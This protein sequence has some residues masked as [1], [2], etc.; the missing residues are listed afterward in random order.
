MKPFAI[1]LDDR[2]VSFARDGKVL[3]SAP[4][5]VWDGST[6]EP[7]GANAWGALRRHPTAASTRHLGSLLSQ[8]VASD[9]AIALVAAELVRRLA[10]QAPAADERVWIAAPARATADGLGAMLAIARHLSLPVD[11]F[12]DSTV[13]TAAALGLERSAIVLELGLYH[14]AATSIHR[15]A[16]QVRRGRTVLTQR[17]GLMAFYQAWLEL[18]STT[19]VKRTRFDPLHDAVTEQQLF[20][21]LPAWARDVAVDGSTSAALTKGE[22]RFEVALTR[23]QFVQVG[24][25]IHREIMRLVHELRP[26]GAAVT[27][28]V[29]G[30]IA[31]LPGLREELEQLVDCELVS[32][33]EGFAAAATSLL[34]LPERATDGPVRLLRRLPLKEQGP[35]AEGLSREL[36]GSR[37]SHVSPPS[38]LLLNGQVYSLG[39]D[40]L[41][42]GRSPVGGARAITLSDGLAGVSRRH[43]TFT[44]DG[45]ELVLLDHSTFGTFVNGE[46]VAERVRVRAGDRVRLGDPGVELALIAVDEVPAGAG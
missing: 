3:S 37:R 11:G 41:V 18:V 32:L 13:A 38:H 40:A 12:V 19:M 21:S 24:E 23:D 36:L 22:G 25:P 2:V 4:S 8:P 39:G 26:A 6:G 29:P 33:P 28:V 7:A 30:M 14:A 15:D 5:A 45:D 46:R 9:R 31:H 42:V 43:C 16:G 44:R 17:G 27:L 10:A 20:D 34:D 1:E 35:L